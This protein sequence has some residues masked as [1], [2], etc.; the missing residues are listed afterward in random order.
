MITGIALTFLINIVT[1]VLKWV[2]GKIGRT[3]T[4]IVVFVLA[5]AAAAFVRFG[6]YIPNLETYI[7]TAVALFSAAVAFYEVVLTYIPFFQGPKDTSQA[8]PQTP[9]G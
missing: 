9:I 5:L 7:A 8:V 2:T 1:A 3:G 4:Q 6:S